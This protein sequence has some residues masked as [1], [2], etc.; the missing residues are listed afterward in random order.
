M[1]VRPLVLRLVTALLAVVQGFAP[2]VASLVD[3]RPA[4]LAI[5]ERAVAHVDAPDSP[6]AFAHRDNC[7][8][9]STA[10]Q[11]DG[12]PMA[13]GAVLTSHVAH[14]PARAAEFAFFGAADRA[15]SRSRAPPA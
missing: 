13:T 5:S 11:L 1:R 3:A 2:A 4:A 10:T 12:A 8:L 6:H 9:C 14:R 15:H 7:V